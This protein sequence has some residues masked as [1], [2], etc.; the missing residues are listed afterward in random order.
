[1]QKCAVVE[2]IVVNEGGK[3]GKVVGGTEGVTVGEERSELPPSAETA[4][5]G[6]PTF[7]FE[8]V[9]A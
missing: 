1:V 2:V 7:F 9:K 4:V 3:T 8:N 5:P 6:Q